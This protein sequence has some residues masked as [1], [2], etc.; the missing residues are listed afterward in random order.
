M[1]FFNRFKK[2]S[3]PPEPPKTQT[4]PA[5]DERKD[6]APA[7]MPQVPEIPVEEL[8]AKL[9]RGEQPL[10]VLA[11]SNRDANAILTAIIGRPVT[12]QNVARPHG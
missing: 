2:A 10:I 7:T 8:K 1:G 9:N 5:Y 11:D 3:P 4:P 6:E 12:D